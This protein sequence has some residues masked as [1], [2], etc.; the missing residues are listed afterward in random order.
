M[1]GGDAGGDGTAGW[2]AVQYFTYQT[3]RREIAGGVLLLLLAVDTGGSRNT[4]ACERPFF[5]LQSKHILQEMWLCI[6]RPSPSMKHL[7]LALPFFGL[8][9]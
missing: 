4:P 5:L 8:L 6:C 9:D 1:D 3:S 2:E 7:L